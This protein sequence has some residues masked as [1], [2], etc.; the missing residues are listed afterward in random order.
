MG[1]EETR[2]ALASKQLDR[3]SRNYFDFQYVIGRGGFGKVN[4]IFVMKFRC[5]KCV[6][7]GQEKYMPSKK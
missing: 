7:K 6:L 4:I 5:G 3:V 2:L 1:Q